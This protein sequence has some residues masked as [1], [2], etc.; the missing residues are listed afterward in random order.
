M[1][2]Q[3]LVDEIEPLSLEHHISLARM[4]IRE[5][6]VQP[7]ENKNGTFINLSTLDPVVIKA[8]KAWV[9]LIEK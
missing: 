3:R 6:G 2:L 5:Y 9:L 7:D 1:E 4:L 8:I